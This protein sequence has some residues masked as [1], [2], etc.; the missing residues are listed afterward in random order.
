METGGGLKPETW[1]LKR[2]AGASDGSEPPEGGTTEPKARADLRANTD[3]EM[4][5]T[6]EETS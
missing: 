2:E 4:V 1:N 5:F 3:V 6:N